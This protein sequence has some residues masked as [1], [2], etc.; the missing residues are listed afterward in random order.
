[1]CIVALCWQLTANYPIVV[2]GNRDEFRARP[3][4]ACQPWPDRPI[5]AGRDLQSG[6]AW[7]GVNPE[8]GRWAVV[9]NVR[10]PVSAHE[11]LRSRGELVADFLDP[12]DQACS[13]LTYARQ[14]AGQAYPGFNL[15]IGTRDQAVYISNRGDGP[16]V[17]APGLYVLSNAALDTP[18]PKVERLRQRVAQEVLPL[19]VQPQTDWLA[20]AF[21]VLQDTVQP[22]IEQLPDTGIG[23]AWEQM[24]GTIWIDQPAY[25]SRASTVLYYQARVDQSGG[26]PWQIVE[27]SFDSSS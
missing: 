18:W 4:L 1:M 3:A 14:L 13:P 16:I 25:G 22:P 9:T 26:M 27:H 5:I 7:F 20:A 24:L 11:G 17:L 15:L 19:L 10:E 21:T 8:A 23:L 2:L 6:G 12:Q